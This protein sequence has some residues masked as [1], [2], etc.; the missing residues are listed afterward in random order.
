[1]SDSD[2]IRRALGGFPDKE[3]QGDTRTMRDELND[4][5]FSI[6]D[7]I[8]RLPYPESKAKPNT[9]G[10][11]GP[12]TNKQ[13]TSVSGG[14]GT[15]RAPSVTSG[16]GWKPPGNLSQNFGSRPGVYSKFGL[17]GHDG[18]D[19]MAPEGTPVFPVNDGIVRT[20]G[21]GSDYGNQI[22]V[23]HAD[24]SQTLYA[25]LSDL[26]N[27]KA[28]DRV[29]KDMQIGMTGNTGN[30]EAPHLHLGYKPSEGAPEGYG[31]FSDPNA[32][33][34][35]QTTTESPRQLY[36]YA[37]EDVGQ[38]VTNLLTQ[39]QKSFETGGVL[40][41]AGEGL[42]IAGGILGAGL[43]KAGEGA[44]WLDEQMKRDPRTGQL[45][46][47]YKPFTDE[48]AD[49]A[50]QYNEQLAEPFAGVTSG[51][52]RALPGMQTQALV[53]EFSRQQGLPTGT[54]YQNDSNPLGNFPAFNKDPLQLLQS[55]NVL[56]AFDS[57]M[58]AVNQYGNEQYDKLSPTDALVAALVLDPLNFIPGLGV[59]K[60]QQANKLTEATQAINRITDTAKLLPDSNILTR[61]A[62]L[63]QTVDSALK[64]VALRG[65][66]ATTIEDMLNPYRAFVKAGATGQFDEVA[67]V[68]TGVKTLSGQRAVKLLEDFGK[69]IDELELGYKATQ[70]ALT[71]G[72]DITKLP[73]TFAKFADDVKAGR[74]KPENVEQGLLDLTHAE[75]I[76]SSQKHMAG[77]AAAT[78]PAKIPTNT[79]VKIASAPADWSRRFLNNVKAAEALVYIGL[80]PW[81]FARNVVNGLTTMALEG[82]NPLWSATSE[83]RRLQK[84]GQPEKAA[85]LRRLVATQKKLTNTGEVVR[86]ALG[87]K[88]EIATSQTG[89]FGS[90]MSRM[91]TRT[92][93]GKPLEW[94][95]DVEE[96]MRAKVWTQT[97]WNAI[98]NTWVPGK[99]FENVDAATAAVL[100]QYRVTEKELHN[101][102]MAAGPNEARILKAVK[103]WVAGVTGAAVDWDTIAAEMAAMG[104]DA[105]NLRAFL[106]E[107]DMD[108]VH[109]MASE[110]ATRVAQGEEKVAVVDEVI[111]RAATEDAAATAERIGLTEIGA[112]GLPVKAKGVDDA[113]LHTR[114]DELNT[115]EQELGDELV[116]LQGSKTKINKARRKEISSLLDQ[117]D[118]ERTQLQEALGMSDTEILFG[119]NPTLPTP[120]KGAKVVT[121]EIKPS[122]PVAPPLESELPPVDIPEQVLS[123]GQQNARSY[124][125]NIKKA[126]G[127][128][129]YTEQQLKTWKPETLEN[130]A[131]ERQMLRATFDDIV[132][133][134][135][136]KGVAT[137]TDKGA[138]NNRQLLNV[139]NKHKA[140]DAQA[141]KTIQDVRARAD[142][143]VEIINNYTPEV[144]ASPTAVKAPPSREQTPTVGAVGGVNDIDD[145]VDGPVP[146][147]MRNNMDNAFNAFTPAQRAQIEELAAQR[148]TA[149]E[150]ADALGTDRQ[151]IR[152]ARQ[153]MGIPSMSRGVGFSQQPNPDFDAW[154]IRRKATKPRNASDA[155]VRGIDPNEMHTSSQPRPVR[156]ATD[157]ISSKEDIAPYL[158]GVT[159]EDTRRHIEGW[160]HPSQDGGIT[161]EFLRNAATNGRGGAKDAAQRILDVKAGSSVTP[162]PA[163]VSSAQ[164][165]IENLRSV[166]VEDEAATR[167]LSRDEMVKAKAR[168][169]A[170]I[171][172]ALLN[173]WS[174]EDVRRVRLGTDAE[175]RINGYLRRAVLPGA[176]ETRQAA[177][178]AAD[179]MDNAVMISRDGETVFDAGL[180]VLSPFQFWRSRFALQSL[181]RV[182]DKPAR[183]AWYLKLRE[184][185][186]QVQDDPRFPKRLRGMMQLPFPFLPEWA[187]GGM[188]YDPLEI[189][190]SIEGAFGLNRFED[191]LT[192]NEIAQAITALAQSGEISMKEAANANANMSGALWEA[193]K[194]RMLELTK[195]HAGA[196]AIADTFKPHLP[197]DIIHKIRTGTAEELGVLFPMTRLIR[198]ASRL[199]PKGTP[200]LNP[201]GKGWNIEGWAKAGLRAIPGLEDVPDWDMWE[202]QRTDKA[203]ADMVG[204]GLISER[205]ALIAMIE[206][207]GDYFE[208]AQARAQEQMR[209]QNYSVFGGQ[210]FAE[211]E[212]EYY[213]SLILQNQ[214][215]DEAVASLGGNPD[216]Y[217]NGEKWDLVKANG[218]TSKKSGS[219]LSTFYDKN[220]VYGARNSVYDVPEAR[221]KNML[222]DEIWNAYNTKGALDKKLMGNDLGEVFQE[223]FR[224]SDTRN[225]DDVTLDQLGEWVRKTRGYVPQQPIIEVG[226]FPEVRYGTLDQNQR[227]GAI[228]ES[229]EQL[230]D[231]DALGPKLNTYSNL[232]GDDKY[233]YRDTVPDLDAYLDWY[234][235]QFRDNPDL[236]KLLNPEYAAAGNAY[237][238]TRDGANDVTRYAVANMERM[239]RQIGGRNAR[240]G[241][242]RG[243]TSPFVPNAP[244]GQQPPTAPLSLKL[245]SVRAQNEVKQ[246]WANPR[247]FLSKDVYG[248]LF[249]LYRKYRQGAQSFDQ[250]LLLFQQMAGGRR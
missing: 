62:K 135:K 212:K 156:N 237:V 59:G 144:K 182:A 209:L 235:Q 116:K 141:F 196:D 189:G 185:Q 220:P 10:A 188:W 234:G 43:G 66:G 172:E 94:Y 96:A 11:A 243:T 103:D 228:N 99:G 155:Q 240:G 87:E 55:G 52:I 24:G 151:T 161:D 223:K 180:G 32:L 227:Y 170:D 129:L 179:W 2:T 27:L 199:A 50:G 202:E 118:D 197:I 65:V 95:R 63:T 6:M 45:P 173:L 88:G 38:G 174:R 16:T 233:A 60:L 114:I 150:I 219:P 184:A 147:W 112:E 124:L 97:H 34:S 51:L 191:E 107:A 136:N 215:L 158:D 72:G 218:L 122:E 221:L 131:G 130:V 160:F 245:L 175:A 145:G 29:T 222:V 15:P 74:I 73:K 231:M 28:G 86:A 177:T 102:I 238:N 9:A 3:K 143:A 162:P 200:V 93:L 204:D 17:A 81:T 105:K 236:S 92:K 121:P 46:A 249:G 133:A 12:T 90:F 54:D 115:Q 239:V 193:T 71:T 205:D 213:K 224:N 53:N 91:L 19:Y 40:G 104:V 22:W 21:A 47:D 195:T 68:F 208:Q 194:T 157:G 187:G 126:D 153:K 117:I 146:D 57:V 67:K 169:Q 8:Y 75:L 149:Q 225:V 192:D 78:F 61:N 203:I 5:F 33:F 139:L 248:E 49:A 229:A 110:I 48:L 190:T 13:G 230:F 70:T 217:S 120:P 113:Q 186:D 134:A 247:F 206:R 132:K 152:F 42:N 80:S 108:K 4:G 64:N 201:D 36:G 167:I 98:Q 25:H 111:A 154:L 127:T 183:L 109:T 23:E 84:L 250:W 159:D 128:P 31:G 168:T 37:G 56:G 216:D 41:A 20:V 83:I 77:K 232:T 89:A 123:E 244:A 148:K 35:Q 30:S 44:N 140:T 138:P 165:A 69:T 1:M 14:V 207:K 176:N 210:I 163:P 142:E 164:E 7:T 106:D 125:L 39:L 246:R 166:A 100:H 137:A 226:Q 76:T 181:R 85:A 58:K 211:G 26:P 79:A 242:S 171:Y 241:A 178:V 198:G 101:I 18:L 82:V 119:K 214:Y